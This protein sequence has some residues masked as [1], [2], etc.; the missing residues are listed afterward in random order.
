MR[1]IGPASTARYNAAAPDVA[2]IG[3]ELGVRY[4]IGG[5]V[6]RGSGVIIDSTLTSVETGEVIRLNRST[7]PTSADALHSNLDQR[8]A[9]AF[10]MQYYE[11]DNVRASQPGHA[12]DAADLTILGWRDLN[13]FAT[14]DDVLR[15]RSRFEAALKVDPESVIALQGLGSTYEIEIGNYSAA[16]RRA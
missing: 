5:R 16:R 6:E 1:V 7:F 3:R 10:R 9:S 11:N 2:Q 14:R 8:V 13:R 15:A 12:V 4:V